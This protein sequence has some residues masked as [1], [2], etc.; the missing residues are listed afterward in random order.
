MKRSSRENQI[1]GAAENLEIAWAF[2]DAA[3]GATAS[4]RCVRRGVA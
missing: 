3:T 4:I 1:V 2:A